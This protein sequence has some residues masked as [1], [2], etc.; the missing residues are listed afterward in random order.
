MKVCIVGGVAG[1]ASAAARLRRLDEKAEIIMFEQGEHISFANCGLPYHLSGKIKEREKLLLQTPASFHKRFKVEVRVKSRV[2]SVNLDEKTLSVSAL[3]T[4]K[5]YV[6]QFDYLVLSPGAVP[7]VPPFEGNNAPAVFTLRDIRD[8]DR[9][10]AK[11]HGVQADGQ[12]RRA[13]VVGAGYI[14]M[15]VAENLQMA[16]WETHVV[17]L[18]P[19]ILSPFDAELAGLLQE[20]CVEKGIVFHLNESVSQLKDLGNHA[21]Q[22]VLRSG[23]KLEATLVILGIGVRPQVELAKKMGLKRTCK[24]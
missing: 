17:E 13:V 22:V 16:G 19:Q 11:I 23:Q 4:G 18:A 20:R 6:E 21:S 14:G 12:A 7:V 9:I 15:E 8:L 24:N 10:M 1:G 5:T 2:D 3:D